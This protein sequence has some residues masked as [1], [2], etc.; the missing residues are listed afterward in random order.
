MGAGNKQQA[1]QCRRTV[2]VR[3]QASKARK[4]AKG[5]PHSTDV[6]W[7]FNKAVGRKTYGLLADEAAPLRTEDE[8]SQLSI[9]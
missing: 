8:P 5:R 9:Q 6:V 2:R 7:V 4:R 1:W 3:R